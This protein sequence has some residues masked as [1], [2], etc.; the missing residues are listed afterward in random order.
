MGK[1]TRCVTGCSTLGAELLQIQTTITGKTRK[2]GL[3]IYLLNKK[4][5]IKTI[6]TAYYKL[7]N[8][9]KVSIKST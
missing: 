5:H 7:N 6:I 3:D 2:F 9:H 8:L 1:R 4:L